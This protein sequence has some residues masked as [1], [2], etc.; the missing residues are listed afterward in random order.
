MKVQCIKLHNLLYVM[1]GLLVFWMNADEIALALDDEIFQA[2][3]MDQVVRV[4]DV[5]EWA[6]DRFYVIET[7]RPIVLQPV[8][9]AV[10]R[11]FFEQDSSGRFV[12]ETGLY[13]TIKK[14]GKT[15]VAALVQRWAAECWGDF[16]EVYHLGNK[17]KQAK[18]R[19]FKIS[20]ASITLAPKHESQDWDVGSEKL[21]YINNSFVQALPVSAAGEAGGNQRLTT[22]TEFH[23]YVYEEDERFFEEL[24]PVP[25]QTLS[26]R[27]IESYA[28][29]EGESNLLKHYWN[30]ALEG[31]QLHDEFPIYGNKAA[32]VVGYIDQGEA[33]RR[34]PWQRGEEGRHY[35]AKAKMTSSPAQ[36]DRL[37][38]NKWVTSQNKLINMAL[39]DSLQ[40]AYH[41]AHAPRKHPVVLA[42]DAAVSGDCTA[43]SVV[44]VG[45]AYNEENQV[46]FEL[47]T[48]I[49]EPEKGKKLDYSETLSP[50]MALMHDK[51]NVVQV[52]YDEYQMHNFMTELH[53][54]N[55]WKNIEFFAFPQG[56]LR[57]QADTALIDRIR[58]GTFRH[59]GNTTLRQHADNADGKEVGDD[60][61][62][63]VKRDNTL[64]IDGVIAVSMGAWQA[65]EVLESYNPS[66]FKQVSVSY[67][68]KRGRR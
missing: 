29:Y 30:L 6:E 54:E 68:R 15:T 18:E 42:V 14:S 67:N 34:M 36:F 33:A 24:Q 38:E 32:G 56:K 10:L 64:K 66:V 12:W 19:A 23:G 61:L 37:H 65:A 11:I 59:S 49:W 48:F 41:E 9:K 20:R 35:Y 39:W 5:V 26:F 52:A 58:R 25:T 46:V 16:G 3:D 17:L 22:W 2:Q 4:P 43:L 21:T 45:D 1:L 50:T 57:L 62:R 51:Y 60:A 8:Q 40:E 13:S 55:A 63:I 44:T 47:E 28:G 27:F 53:K 7:K 31:E